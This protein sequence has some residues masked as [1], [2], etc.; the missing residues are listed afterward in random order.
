MVKNQTR[1][2]YQKLNLSLSALEE[3]T[4]QAVLKFTASKFN[5]FVE[6]VKLE[7]LK[8]KEINSYI[9]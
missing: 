2:S 7:E 9:F 3:M 4:K 5:E 1:S 8:Y 6:H